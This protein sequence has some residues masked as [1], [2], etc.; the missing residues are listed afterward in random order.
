[1]H[2]WYSLLW[3][4]TMLQENYNTLIHKISCCLLRFPERYL[5][6][7]AY[8]HPPSHVRWWM[9]PGFTVKERDI[10][11]VLTSSCQVYQTYRQY[12]YTHFTQS[13]SGGS[14]PGVVLYRGNVTIF[15]KHFL[16]CLF[17]ETIC[18]QTY[19][20]LHTLQ[21][22]ISITL[23]FVQ[24]FHLPDLSAS[25]T[26]PIFL[27]ILYTGYCVTTWQHCQKFVFGLLY[28]FTTTTEHVRPNT[29]RL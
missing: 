20:K 22:H 19:T 8:A 11:N 28:I 3:S 16:S 1:M 26:D 6:A 21:P 18:K 27:N 29:I 23:S 25:A 4:L 9:E 24:T 5:C 2:L 12:W 7:W 10:Q 13:Y 15:V 17:T 14:C